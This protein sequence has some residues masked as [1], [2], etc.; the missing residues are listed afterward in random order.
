[1]ANDLINHDCVMRPALKSQSEG[2]QGSSKLVSTYM[3]QE[4]G[5]PQLR[6]TEAPALRTLLDLALCYLFI[7]L[8]IYT[9]YN[10][11]K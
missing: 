5:A 10:E 4:V 3:C 7:W 6:G 2:A 8:F 1:M 9:L 11:L